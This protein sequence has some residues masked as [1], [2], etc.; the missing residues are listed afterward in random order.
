MI[1]TKSK[2]NLKPQSEAQR[3]SIQFRNLSKHSDIEIRSLVTRVNNHPNIKLIS[4]AEIFDRYFD[5]CIKHQS[6]YKNNVSPEAMIRV[7]LR[8]TLSLLELLP[9]KES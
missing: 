4:K 8:N 5:A 3:I 1:L 9:Y 7:A 6:K 2:L